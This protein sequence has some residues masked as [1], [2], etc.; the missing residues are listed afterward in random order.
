[1]DTTTVILPAD[2]VLFLE[3]AGVGS[4]VPIQRLG[5]GASN[6]VFKVN[7]GKTGL[8]LKMPCGKSGKGLERRRLFFQICRVLEL[9][10]CTLGMQEKR[11]V[12]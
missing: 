10:V 12:Y 11:L 3:M 5:R 8:V 6:E 4:H 7:V 2:V 9:P 1:M